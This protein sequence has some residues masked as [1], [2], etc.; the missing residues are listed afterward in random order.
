M[1]FL[2]LHLEASGA[3]PIVA[4]TSGSLSCCLRKVKSPFELRGGTRD[5]YQVTTGEW[6]LILH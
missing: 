1:V 2:K 3:S 6:S 5:C 4:G